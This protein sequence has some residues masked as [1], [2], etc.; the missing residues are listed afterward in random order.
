M[1]W[2][3]EE[4]LDGSLEHGIGWDPLVVEVGHGGTLIVGCPEPPPG[5]I[6]TAVA[7][8]DLGWRVGVE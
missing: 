2:L 5:A 1:R 7:A 8:V 6:A 4:R 3:L